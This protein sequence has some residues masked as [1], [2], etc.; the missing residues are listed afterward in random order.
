MSLNEQQHEINAFGVGTHLVTCQKQPALGC[1]YK[2]VEKSGQPKIKISQDVVKITIPGKKRCY[3]LYGKEGFAILDLMTLDEEKEPQVNTEILCRHPFEESKRAK[4]IPSRIEKLQLQ[5]W[6][7]KE[8]CQKLPTLS[9]MKKRVQL[10]IGDLRSDHKRSLNPTPYKV[11]FHHQTSNSSFRFLSANSS[12]TFCMNSGF[13]TH[14][15]D[16]SNNLCN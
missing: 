10:S 2:L 5:F 13:E 12:T 14:Q 1:V 4:V 9:E 8:I 6:D 11:D 7:G 3:R 15:S 16:N